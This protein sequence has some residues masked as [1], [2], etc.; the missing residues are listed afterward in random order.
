[1]RKRRMARRFEGLDSEGVFTRIYEDNVWGMP[2]DGIRYNSGTGSRTQDI[3][4]PYVEAVGEF[5]ASL[6][7]KPDVVD[8]GCGDFSVGKRIR[9]FARRYVACDVVK[10]LIAD[11]LAR[12]GNLDVDFRVLDMTSDT[13]PEGDVVTIRQV[14][15]HLS[16]AQI[17]GVLPKLAEKYRYL[18]LTEHL[19]AGDFVPNLDKPAGP[20]TR[21]GLLIAGGAPSGVVITEPPFSLKVTECRL[22]CQV[23]ESGAVIRTNL[24]VL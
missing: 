4:G 14:F 15:Q 24:Y 17:Q 6:G 19:P 23:E 7:T 5:L 20:D 12:C 9:P 3:V 22:L 18:I 10:P 11:N 13:L 1:M 8:L 2:S 21:I 16:N